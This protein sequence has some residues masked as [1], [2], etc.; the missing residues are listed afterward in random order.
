MPQNHLKTVPPTGD[1][2]FKHM[3]LWEL[4]PFKLPKGQ[5]V[6]IS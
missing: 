2:A 3:S 6:E 4:F 5:I 1:Q